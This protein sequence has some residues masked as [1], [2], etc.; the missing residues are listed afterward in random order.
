[1]GE[2]SFSS[3]YR[4][5]ILIIFWFSPDVPLLVKAGCLP[6]TCSM[7]MSLHGEHSYMLGNLFQEIS[8]FKTLFVLRQYCF[9]LFFSPNSWTVLLYM[10]ISFSKHLGETELWVAFLRFVAL[11][12]KA[13]VIKEESSIL[14]SADPSRA[15]RLWS[16]ITEVTQ[17]YSCCQLR[18]GR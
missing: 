18:I 17:N 1:M 7:Y 10:F 12:L 6:D 9:V 3:S 4:Y 15:L 5:C 13:Q 14:N 16:M 2:N 8:V 11:L